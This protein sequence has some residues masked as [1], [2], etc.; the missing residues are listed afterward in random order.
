MTRISKT[1]EGPES[2]PDS[3]Q[4]APREIESLYRLLSENTTDLIS[5]HTDEGVF[6]YLS[7]ACENLLGYAPDELLGKSIYKYFHPDDLSAVVQGHFQLLQK[8]EH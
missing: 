6:L 1:H 7:P 8:S 4:A 5:R 2:G 3:A